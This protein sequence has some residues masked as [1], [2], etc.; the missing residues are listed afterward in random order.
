MDSLK[1]LGLKKRW[2]REKL[3]EYSK[4]SG[5]GKRENM[6]K[7]DGYSKFS[8]TK[9]RERKGNNYI[10]NLNYLGLKKGGKIRWL[11]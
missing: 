8:G 3:Y 5:I 6:G 7:V 1:Y 2:T 4:F 9:K 10:D 11:L